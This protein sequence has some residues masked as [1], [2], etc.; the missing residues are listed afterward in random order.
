MST[1][2][3][4]SGVNFIKFAAHDRVVVTN[5]CIIDLLIIWS[6]IGNDRS[7]YTGI[8][9]IV[10]VIIYTWKWLVLLLRPLLLFYQFLFRVGNAD[11][12]L[13]ILWWMLRLLWLKVIVVQLV[14]GTAA[15]LLHRHH[16]SFFK[17]FL[18]FFLFKC[19]LIIIVRAFVRLNTNS[20]IKAVTLRLASSILPID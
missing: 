1:A 8:I 3:Y 17:L 14:S 9:T 20:G 4:C 5:I 10:S 19:L 7:I 18:I 6:R 12:H 16:V 11:Y 13:I 15:I 2:S